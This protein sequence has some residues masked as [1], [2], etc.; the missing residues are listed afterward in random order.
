MKTALIYDWFVDGAGGGERAFEAIFNLFPSPIFTLIQ[1]PQSIIGASFE[2]AEFHRS[3]IQKLPRALQK[4][5]SYLPLFPL[6]IE[7]LDVSPYDLVISCSHCVAKGVVTHADQ[8][9]LNYCYTPMRYAWDL[10]HQYLKE[11]A[12]QG[13]IK[14]FFA[15]LFLHYLRLW[16]YQASRRVD[17]YAAISRHVAKRVAK[18]YGRSATVIYPPVN[19]EFYTLGTKKEDYYLVASRLVGYKKIDAVVDAFGKMPEKKLVVIGDGPDLR[20]IEQ[21]ATSNIELIGHQTDESLRQYYQK[22]KAFLF[23][24]IEDFGIMPVEAQSCGTPVIAFRKGGSLETVKEGE[25]GLFFEEQTPESIRAAV[26][27]FETI[28]DTFDPIK[29]RAHAETFSSG[30]FARE[31]SEWVRKEYKQRTVLD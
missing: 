4:Y 31:F 11:D 7:Q 17:A 1:S 28:Q 26:S 19:T 24:P 13:K 21:K 18:T 27:R 29:I 6:A 14:G 25:T 8:I 12:V 9:H 22:A 10:Y 23:A 15:R 16:D 30:R 5:R 2:K 3:F 20:K